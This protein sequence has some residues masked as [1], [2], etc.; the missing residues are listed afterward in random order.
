MSVLGLAGIVIASLAVAADWPQWRGLNRAAKVTDFKPPAKWPTQLTK[1]WSVPVGDGDA[2]PSLVGDK[3]YVFAMQDGNE[4]IR[5]LDAATGNELWQD[6]YE[7]QGA[8][9][10]AGGHA[11]PRASPTVAEG[12]VV[13]IG[14]RGMVSSLDAQTGKV[15]WRKDDFKS[16]PG[17]FTSSSPI[18]VDGLC[19]A[20]LGGER[21]GGIVA[22]DLT[23]GDEKWKWTEDGPAYASPVLMQIGGDK[24]VVAMTAG[25]IVALGAGDGKLAWEAVAGGGGGGR[26]GRGGPPGGGFGGQPGERGERGGPRGERGAPPGRGRE[27][28]EQAETAARAATAKEEAVKQEAVKQDTEKQEAAKLAQAATEQRDGGAQPGG[29]RR[30]GPGGGRGGRGGGMGGGRSYNASTPVVDGNTIYYGGPTGIKAVKLEKDG[31]KVVAKELWNNPEATVQYNSPVLKDGKLFGLTQGGIFFCVNVETGKTAWLS[32]GAQSEGGPP[33]G[34]AQPGGA[35]PGGGR[36][37]RGGRGGGGIGYGSIVDAGAVLLAITPASEL[38][39]I[40]PIDAAYSEIARIKVADSPV[41][42]HLVVAGNRLFV[43]DRDAV[44]LLTVE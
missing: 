7:A 11:G 10:P 16:W 4:I 15:L 44:S 22:Y 13:T 6:K 2:T 32:R 37:G 36:G 25:K 17:F 38:V 35:Q 42:A 3:L 19:I 24:L 28:G 41:Y 43:K 27:A 29:E 1:K 20:Q 12:K 26:G 18:V 23:S 33:A 21:A 9:G 39:V 14:V 5:C 8:T 34:G 40:E 31:D 30:G